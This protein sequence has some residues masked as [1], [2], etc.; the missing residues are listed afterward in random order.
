[1]RRIGVFGLLLLGCGAHAAVAPPPPPTG[2]AGAIAVAKGST[3]VAPRYAA[4]PPPMPAF[5]DPDR[6]K[7]IGELAAKIDKRVDGYFAKEKPPSL[8]VVLV[9]DGKPVVTKLLGQRDLATKAPPTTKTLYRIGSITKT[10][11]GEAML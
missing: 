7:K 8:A 9:V 5:V 2:G 10:F 6:A 3:P 1:M 4:V 11:T